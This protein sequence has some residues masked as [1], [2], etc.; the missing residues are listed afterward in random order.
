MNHNMS[1]VMIIYGSKF[2]P[3]TQTLQS[4]LS[5][6]K[7]QE[8]AGNKIYARGEEYY[9]QGCVHLLYHSAS[10]ATAEVQG[11]HPYRAELKLTAKELKA[12]CTC[13]A[14]SDYGFC[15]HAVALGLFLL[16]AP[17]PTHKDSN[18]KNMHE[19][20]FAKR[21]P[22]ITGWIK[23]GWIEIGRDG[24]STSI[25]RVCDEGG[26]TW[27]GGTRHKS[28]DKI[29]QEAEQAIAELCGN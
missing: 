4:F 29:L 10:T 3:N 25:I 1:P 24:Y 7:L 6:K 12:D 21:Y 8:L 23:D 20:N 27:E 13:P 11:T 14:I 9:E 28:M 15:K 26:T 18:D 16:N 19:D 17:P 5:Y 2:M 22:N